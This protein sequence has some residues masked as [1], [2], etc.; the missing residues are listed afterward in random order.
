MEHA[1]S[2]A[3]EGRHSRPT[4]KSEQNTMF[5]GKT[6]TPDGLLARVGSRLIVTSGCL[7]FLR[8]HV[9]RAPVSFLAEKFAKKVAS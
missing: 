3:T 4:A 7:V 9:D 6:V 1:N 8:E 5:F 2:A